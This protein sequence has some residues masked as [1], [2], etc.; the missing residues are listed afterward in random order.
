MPGTQQ[1]LGEGV[2][3][4]DLVVDDEDRVLGGCVQRLTVFARW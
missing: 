1:N 4:L 3:N 2:A